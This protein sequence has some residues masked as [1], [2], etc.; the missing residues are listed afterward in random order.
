MSPLVTEQSDSSEQGQ[1][2]T[3]SQNGLS[4]EGSKNHSVPALLLWVGT[5]STTPACSKPIQP[6]HFQA[7]GI[8]IFS[9]LP[10]P[11]PHHPTVNNFCLISNLNRLSF[12]LKPKI[13]FHSLFFLSVLCAGRAFPAAALPAPLCWCVS[14]C[15]Y[16]AITA[17]A[18]SAQTPL[19]L[20]HMVLS[21]DMTS[22][23]LP[24]FLSQICRIKLLQT[25]TFLSLS[26]FLP[27][28]R[29]QQQQ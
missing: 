8:H 1:P 27:Y 14:E 5:P 2:I 23:T 12:S 18:A 24:A 17:S 22:H 15:P 26:F 21:L 29:Q 7:W 25:P 9:G 20:V 28:P 4:C 19:H 16:Q 10:V 3:E 13:P 6:A 11:V